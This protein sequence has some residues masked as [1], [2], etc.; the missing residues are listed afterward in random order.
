MKRLKGASVAQ[1]R[2]PVKFPFGP[3]AA[4]GNRA[5]FCRHDSESETAESRLGFIES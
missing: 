3:P 4:G 5:S 2:N 1:A